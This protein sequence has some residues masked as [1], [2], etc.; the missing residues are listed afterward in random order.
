MSLLRDRILSLLFCN[1]RCILTL[2]I[3]FV[4]IFTLVS[5][6]SDKVEGSYYTFQEDLVGSYLTSHPE[7]YS[8]F[9]K[10]LDTTKVLGLLNAYGNY[11]CF[12]P[13]NE[14]LYEFYASQ[15]R[16]SLYDYPYDTLVKIVYDHIIRDAELTTSD[17]IS[18]RLPNLTMSNR[19]LSIRIEASSSDTIL[20]Y[21]VNNYS[22]IIDNEVPVHNGI[23][24]T[25]EKVL[26]PTEFSLVEALASNSKFSLFYEA[27]MATNL[28]KKLNLVDDE[29]YSPNAYEDD[30]ALVNTWRLGTLIILPE[31]K[32]F[33]YTALV[34][35]DS[36]YYSKGISSLEKMKVYAADI[37]DKVFPEDAGITDITN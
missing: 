35:S 1:N 37:Y 18:G 26:K 4:F 29:T 11:T 20:S 8:E 34:E 17:F 15:G 13:T 16:S 7:T 10:M 22:L 24:H 14:A 32:K 21:Y 36:L 30:Y 27:L 12:A 19:F 2:L 23:I 5:C 6:D 25:I 3:G 33:G 9:T 31:Y 28:Y